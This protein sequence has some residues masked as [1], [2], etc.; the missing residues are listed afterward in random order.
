MKKYSLLIVLLFCLA[1]SNLSFAQFAKGQKD[2]NIGIGLGSN[3]GLPIGASLDFGITDNISLGAYLGYASKTEELGF[4]FVSYKWNYTAILMGARAAY[5][6]KL[7]DNLD[8][9]GGV[10]LGYNYGSVSL[11]GDRNGF[12]GAEPEYGGLAWAGFIGG[13]Y[14]FSERM[15]AFAELGYGIAI[16]Q[17]GLNVKF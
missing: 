12:F 8:T 14:R 2:L 10:L 13:R 3:Y 4:G 6:L 16:L 11:Q 5:H 7:V 17:A 9:Y 15:G 1:G